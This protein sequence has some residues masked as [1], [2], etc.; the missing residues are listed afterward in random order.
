METILKQ[1]KSRSNKEFETLLNK[2]LEKRSFIEN[3][4]VQGVIEEIGKKWVTVDLNLKSN[5][6]IP[7]AEFVLS[8]QTEMLKVGNSIS[9]LIERIENK[10]G[11]VIA[12]FE[13]ARRK[14][15]W[16]YMTRCFKEGK[17]VRGRIVSKTRGGMIVDSGG[18]LMFLPGS[19]VSLSPQN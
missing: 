16:D 14:K 3:T 5:C 18:C 1:D 9:V 10:N 6:M 15:S 12:S 17:T 2:D 8:Q 4:I 13:K 7:I 11:E 19:Q